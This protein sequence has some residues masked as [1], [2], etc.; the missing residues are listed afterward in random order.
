MSTQ[1]EVIQ[2]QGIGTSRTTDRLAAGVASATSVVGVLALASAIMTPPRSGPFCSAD[3]VAYPFTDAAAFVPRDYLWMYP[4][5]LLVTLF[6]VLAVCIHDAAEPSRRLFSGAG[7]AFAVIAASAVVI[8][9]GIQLAVLQPSMVNGQTD[10]LA[11][12][13]QYNPHGIFIALEDIGYLTMGLAFLLLAPAI[14]RRSRLERSTRRLLTAGGALTVA[15]LVLLSAW[16][17]TNLDYRFEVTA[18]FITWLVLIVSGILLNRLF[19]RR[20]TTRAAGLDT[21]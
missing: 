4:A 20:A 18:I 6:V 3:C 8:D 14:P 17:R 7:V 13:S 15:A 5:L 12:F 2:G 16:Y 10:G 19:V 11:L 21:R 9:Y 1:P